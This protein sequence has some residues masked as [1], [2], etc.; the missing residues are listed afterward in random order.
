MRVIVYLDEYAC[1]GEQPIRYHGDIWNVSSCEFCMC[2]NGQV[3]CH[4]AV[5][6]HLRCTQDQVLVQSVGK[7]C[8]EC[9]EPPNCDF[10]GDT[11]KDGE[12]WHPD[13][14]SVCNCKDGETV[15]Y[16]N[17]CPVCPQG[18]VSVLQLGECCGQCQ[19]M[20]C[21]DMCLT[22]SPDDPQ[23]CTKCHVTSM[24]VQDGTCV[25]GCSEGK[26]AT[27]NNQCQ[28]C[29]ETC[30][31]CIDGTQHH[32][33]K[34]KPGLLWRNGQCVPRCDRNYFQEGGQCIA[35]HRSCSFCVGPWSQDCQSCSSPGQVLQ[36]GQ[37]VDAC[38]SNYYLRN[39][40]CLECPPT[41]KT[42]SG[43]GGSCTSCFAGFVLHRTQC[44]SEC[45]NGF[46][47]NPDGFCLR[48]TVAF[49]F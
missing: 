39:K 40:E 18:S 32:C 25:S 3:Q 49:I 10:A 17:S 23:Q 42:C 38:Q 15:C 43:D 9:I 2:Q 22:C 31:T 6:E 36:E 1:V 30:Q 21:S 27:R 45:P 46:Y 33:V 29:H 35:C 13:P 26:F 24:M 44:L 41:C 11:F 48:K 5:C 16:Q 12:T 19:P 7:C 8:P 37:C 34:C 20:P 14:C 47:A 28:A 4:T